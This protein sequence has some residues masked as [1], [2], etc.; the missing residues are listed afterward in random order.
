MKKSEA[1]E[2]IIAELQ[3]RL[4]EIPYAGADG[5]MVYFN[6]LQRDRPHLFAF[7]SSA[8]KWQ[9]VHGWMLKHRLV[10]R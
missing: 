9:V 4:P 5:G 7:R 3:Q 6:Q 1:E 2:L 10:T 8:E